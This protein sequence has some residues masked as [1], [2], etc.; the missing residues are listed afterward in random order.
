M[1]QEASPRELY[2][3]IRSVHKSLRL[4]A[5]A[6]PTT[7][8]IFYVVCYADPKTQKDFVFWEDILQAF[9]EGL[10]ARDGAKMVPFL[11]GSD[12]KM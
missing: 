11:R 12:L 4:S 5:I 9:E 8:D 6:P 1:V 2:Q 3:P 7:D 10:H